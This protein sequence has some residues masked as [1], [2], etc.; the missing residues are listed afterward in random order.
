LARSIDASRWR[1]V[2]YDFDDGLF[3]LTVYA[4]FTEDLDE[5]LRDA[6]VD[7]VLQGVL[8]ERRRMSN[9]GRYDVKVTLDPGQETIAIT[10][11]AQHID[12]LVSARG[13]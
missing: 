8:G 2:L 1:Y 6:A 9:V 4:L 7:I 13:P 3:E 5:R 10:S 11:L 12:D